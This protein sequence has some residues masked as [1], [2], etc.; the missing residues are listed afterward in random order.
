MWY[1]VTYGQCKSKYLEY[2]DA[3]GALTLGNAIIMNSSNI[4]LTEIYLLDNL[5]DANGFGTILV[6]GHK[7]T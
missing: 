3:A 5:R 7:R 4:Y 1:E 2:Q 6:N